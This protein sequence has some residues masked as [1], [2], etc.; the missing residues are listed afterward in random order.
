M[1]SE[2]PPHRFV[3]SSASTP[4][5][6][7]VPRP[8]S[9]KQMS[10]T[11][12]PIHASSFGSSPASMSLPSIL[13]S[14]RRKYSCRGIR[15]ERARVRQHAHE[16]REQ[17]GVGERVDLQFDALLLVHEPPAA[18]ELDLAGDA[19]ILEIP[20]HRREHVVVHA[21]LEVV[22]DRLRGRAFFE[23]QAGRGMRRAKPRASQSPMESKPTSRPELGEHGRDSRCGSAPRCSCLVQPFSASSCPKNNH[24][25]AGELCRTPTPLSWLAGA[26]LV[27]DQRRLRVRREVGKAAVQAVVAGAA[28]H[29]V[30]VVVPQSS[31]P[32]TGLSQLSRLRRWSARSS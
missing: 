18:A 15:H 14:T 29:L 19:A 16:A 20:G 22:E 12:R 28:A 21:G 7:E 6:S 3:L 24:Q 8:R 10:S 2:T 32:S 1:P 17:P 30:E 31:A 9:R 5:N 25:V 13:H 26:H 4:G 11:M 27:E 23:A